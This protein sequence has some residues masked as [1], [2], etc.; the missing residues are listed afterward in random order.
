MFDSRCEAYARHGCIVYATARRLEAMARLLH[1]NI[2]KLKLDV[3]DDDQV[4]EAVE[5][6]IKREGRIDVLVNNA[7]SGAPGKN[8]LFPRKITLNSP[9]KIT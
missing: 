2:H 9:T 1:S 5:T 8:E 3:L 6:I 7:G 4:K